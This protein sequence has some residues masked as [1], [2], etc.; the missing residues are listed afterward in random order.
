[1]RALLVF[2]VYT[3]FPI[4]AILF[5]IWTAIIA[6][7]EGGFWG[8]VLTLIFPGIGELYWMFKTW[9]ENDAYT[10]LCIIHLIG[11]FL[12]MFLQRQPED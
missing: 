8:G 6:F 7:S 11:A 5:H 9:G 10:I 1:M 3:V 12:Y 4:T 2:F